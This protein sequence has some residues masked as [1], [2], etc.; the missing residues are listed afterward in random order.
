M[1]AT[2][3]YGLMYEYKMIHE[4]NDNFHTCKVC[5]MSFTTVIDMIEHYVKAKHN[6]CEVCDKQFS[7]KLR[8]NTHRK[9]HKQ[10]HSSSTTRHS[11]MKIPTCILGDKNFT[12]SS[13][14]RK[15]QKSHTSDK[16]FQCIMCNQRFAWASSLKAHI[17]SHTI[18]IND[19]SQSG[20][21]K[22]EMNYTSAPP[23]DIISTGN[24]FHTCTVCNTSFIDASELREHYVNMKHNYCNI[25]D[26]L[27]SNKNSFN[28]HK[29]MHREEESFKCIICGLLLKCA[30]ALKE[31][32]TTHISKEKLHVCNI[33]N[34]E[35]DSLSALNKHWRV[36][37]DEKFYTCNVCN[38][39][40]TNAI[41][42]GE[43]NLKAKH[44][45]CEICNKQLNSRTSFRYHE[46]THKKEKRF[47]CDTCDMKFSFAT[48]LKKHNNSHITSL[49]LW[50]PN[51]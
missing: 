23:F 39:S 12:R 28:A 7:T 25:C 34:Q 24:N 19:Q 22:Y 44:N 3:P 5:N 9:S 36:H 26:K 11:H 48:E 49:V 6:Y 47:S 45:Y 46:K 16:R 27:F 18:A 4:T 31:H 43:H 32:T 37:Q 38:I 40:F 1:N 51:D 20:L 29:R 42:L 50:N 15:H 8:Y 17:K 10:N 41:D 35:F 2:L 13:N 30:S 33:C 21:I 14:L